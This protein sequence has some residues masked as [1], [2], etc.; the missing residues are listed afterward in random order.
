MNLSYPGWCFSGVNFC[1]LFIS[2]VRRS[3]KF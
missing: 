2:S 1:A 3:A